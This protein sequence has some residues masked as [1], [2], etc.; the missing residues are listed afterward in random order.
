ML[1]KVPK[2]KIT[3]MP[4]FR[5]NGMFNFQMVGMGKRITI[6]SVTMF[7]APATTNIAFL[8]PQLPSI[9]VSQL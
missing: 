1:T 7:V 3:T 9:E 6:K 4:S 2:Q 5:R 8:S